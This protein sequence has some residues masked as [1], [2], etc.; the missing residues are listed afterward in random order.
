MLRGMALLLS[1]SRLLLRLKCIR[2]VRTLA[3]TMLTHTSGE[4][5]SLILSYSYWLWEKMSESSSRP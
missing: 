5:K 4:G 2:M 1:A 3:A